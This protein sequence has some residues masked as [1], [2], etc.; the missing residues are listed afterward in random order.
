MF[1]DVAQQILRIHEVIAGIH[2]AVVLHHERIA[3]GLGHGAHPGLHAAPDGEGRVEHLDIIVSDIPSHPLVEHVA[4]ESPVAFR[5]YAP[6]GKGCPFRLRRDYKRP[7]IACLHDSELH[8][9]Q[10]LHIMTPDDIPEKPVDL[11]PTLLAEFVNHTQSI[12]LHPAATE[13]PHRLHHPV[14]G[15]LAHPVAPESIVDIFRPVQRQPDQ[16]S[17]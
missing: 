9:R 16:K 8:G 12:E 6:G 2:I 14:E 17:V 13:H 3:A 7:A 11:R 10:E 4:K 15:R 5:R 1:F